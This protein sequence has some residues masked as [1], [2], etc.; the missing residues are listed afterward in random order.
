VIVFGA[1]FTP[2]PP[3]WPGMTPAFQTPVVTV[4]TFVMPVDADVRSVM[5]AAT[6]EC[7]AGAVAPPLT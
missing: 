6:S 3:Y 5:L 7:H 2:V 4:P 1:L